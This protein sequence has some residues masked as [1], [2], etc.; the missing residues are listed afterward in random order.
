MP[1][2]DYSAPVPL[3]KFSEAR[4]L[5]GY[6]SGLD[7]LRWKMGLIT[8]EETEVAA[9]KKYPEW[10][11]QH[12]INP[13]PDRHARFLAKIAHSYVV[14]EMGIEAFHALV[15]DI[16]LGK[17]DDYYYTVGGSWDPL[18]PHPNI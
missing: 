14:G 4:I 6:P 8:D 9:Q 16:I 5:N 1:V 11:Q 18:P 13:R 15:P 2:S 3:Y 7:N 12:H 10:D 17:S